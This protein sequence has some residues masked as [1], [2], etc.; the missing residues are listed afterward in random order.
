MN[1]ADRAFFKTLKSDPKL[2]TMVSEPVRN[3][4]NGT[5]TID[6]ARKVVGPSGEFIGLVLGAMR[7]DYFEQ[8]YKSIA[9]GPDGSIALFRR[10]GLLLAR[11]PHIDGT[12]GQM[13]ANSPLFGGI[14]INADHGVSRNVGVMDGRERLVAASALPHHPIVVTVTATQHHCNADMSKYPLFLRS[15]ARSAGRRGMP[16]IAR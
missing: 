15:R 4:T 2:S 16:C 8:F 13:Y 10:D 1:I 6:I 3:R 9:A 7:L 11:Y 5:S 12:I 14:L